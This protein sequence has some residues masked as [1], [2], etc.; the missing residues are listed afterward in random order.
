MSNLKA[1]LAQLEALTT[2]SKPK[3]S[4][5]FRYDGTEAQAAEIAELN[6]QGVKTVT[7]HRSED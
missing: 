2:H 4:Q 3:P 5:F 6:R 7:F 1:R